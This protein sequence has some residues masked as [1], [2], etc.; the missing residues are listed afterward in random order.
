VVI[1]RILV[2]HRIILVFSGIPQSLPSLEC[3]VFF[4]LFLSE[5][6][7]NDVFLRVC[8]D[9]VLPLATPITGVDGTVMNEI[10]LP[11]GSEVRVNVTAS[12]NDPNI[13]GPDAFEWK[14]ERW[15]QPLPETVTS[16]RIPG[17][18]SNLLV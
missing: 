14:P 17:V 18:F 13:W 4:P 10:P 6:S 16:A 15:L 11:K 9:M 3:K 7:F 5:G 1:T 8:Q 2:L 12:N